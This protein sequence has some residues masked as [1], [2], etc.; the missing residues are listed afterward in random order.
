[1][2]NLYFSFCLFLSSCVCHANDIEP[3]P[4]DKNEPLTEQEIAHSKA[5]AQ[6]TLEPMLY[7]GRPV[8]DGELLPN[9]NVGH[10]SFTVVGPETV[11]GAGH[12][13][14]T[15]SKI[16][17]AFKGVRYSG[18]CT[19]H[20]NFN[21][22][23]LLNDYVLCKFSPK[24]EFPA[25]GSLGVYPTEVGQTIVLNGYGRGS[26]GGKLHVGKIPIARIRDQ[27]IF[28]E[29]SVVLGSGDSGSSAYIDMDDFKKGPFKI[30]SVN[31][32]AGG[33]MSI[34]N[35]TGD[36]RA[37]SFF[38]DFAAK[39]S[40]EICGVNRDCIDAPKPPDPPI[41]PPKPPEV[42]GF[43]SIEKMLVDTLTTRL[44]FFKKGLAGCSALK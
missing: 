4:T 1:M 33:N 23:T 43:C 5:I 42:P 11:V 34:L 3:M 22:N 7:G 15:G 40:V 13:N 16:A 24:A 19:R 6:T 8:E 38:K 30:V 31:S 36:S 26:V 20:P 27:E 18:P 21:N 9:V 17:F 25:Y 41:D 32:R 14:S 2:K 44:E 28:T 39:N 12:C 37:Q 29:G 10:C 35:M